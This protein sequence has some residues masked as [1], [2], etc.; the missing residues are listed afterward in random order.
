M[1]AGKGLIARLGNSRF[2]C[3]RQGQT[4][5]YGLLTSLN[6]MLD[7]G[8]DQG[9]TFPVV[10]GAVK[11]QLQLPSNEQALQN[12]VSS[13]LG[14]FQGQGQIIDTVNLPTNL[15][16]QSFLGLEVISL[17]IALKS[18]SLLIVVE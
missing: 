12:L 8:Q 13:A 14:Q 9:Q 17:S 1:S 2:Y 18:H 4:D 10:E 5:L 15:N 11:S 7:Q 16:L 6:G 3:F